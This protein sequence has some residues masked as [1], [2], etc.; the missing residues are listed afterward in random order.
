MPD[1][2]GKLTG[3][4]YG[5]TKKYSTAATLVAE[6]AELYKFP[7]SGASIQA[8]PED[9]NNEY[10][11]STYTDENGKYE[12]V[13]KVGVYKVTAR[14]KNNQVTTDNTFN[15]VNN[16]YTQTITKKIS[17]YVSQLDFLII[18][19]ENRYKTIEA[20]NNGY[21]GAKLSIYESSQADTE[22]TVEIINYGGSDGVNIEPVTLASSKEVLRCTVSSESKIG[23]TVMFSIPNGHS[24]DYSVLY[25][26]VPIDLADDLEDVLNPNN[27]DNH[28]EYYVTY[29][30]DE[31]DKDDK[32]AIVY[33][34]V[35]SFS[36][37]TVAI[38]SVGEIVLAL[39][40]P[41]AILIYVVCG[42][43]AAV[44]FIIPAFKSTSPPIYY[45]KKKK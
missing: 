39:G 12:L 31:T 37:H 34:S 25:D 23:K 9:G 44:L 43:I 19:S 42:A 6:K 16:W 18:L 41:T 33:V 20:I 4:V 29:E 24:S 3:I 13:L 28:A 2:Y 8:I 10:V 11:Q 40:G 27:D 22:D 26:D 7:L 14:V 17:S 15:A 36:E 32:F 5:T 21:I 45:K 1:Q 35:S 30:T 38:I